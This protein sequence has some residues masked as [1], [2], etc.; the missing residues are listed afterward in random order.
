MYN[1]MWNYALCMW[2]FDVIYQTTGML[3]QA[4]LILFYL[5]NCCYSW[6]NES[7][8]MGSSSVTND[9]R[10]HTVAL[11]AVSFICV[12]SAIELICVCLHT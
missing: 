7:Q 3:F 12:V 6:A 9:L 1:L 10:Q 2:R 11:E 4:I 8:F 5:A